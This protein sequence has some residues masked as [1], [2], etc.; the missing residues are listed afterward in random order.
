MPADI[1]GLHKSCLVIPCKFSYSSY[2]PQ[3]PYRIVWYQ[4]VSRGYPVVFDD[5]NPTSVID[6]YRGRTSLYDKNTH[7]DCSL[8]I[9]HLAPH[10]NGDRIYTWIDP[11]YIGW[12]TFKFYD[13]S[14]LIH[15]DCKCYIY[16]PVCLFLFN[17]V[18]S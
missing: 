8:V 14:T 12:R 13:F 4:H 15:I 17:Q 6:K 16:L 18:N 9:D 3:N 7:G 11:E 2:P 5:W 10:H 1:H